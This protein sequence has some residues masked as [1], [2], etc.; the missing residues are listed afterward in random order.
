M[1]TDNVI[2]RH[3][4]MAF[5]PPDLPAPLPFHTLKLPR[6]T[7]HQ[8]AAKG[9]KMNERMSIARRI[10]CAC[11]V[12]CLAVGCAP[13]PE[14]AGVL[15]PDGLA[16]TLDKAVDAISV[17]AASD[18]PAGPVEQ[19]TGDDGAPPL[20]DETT[21]PPVETRS[22]TDPPVVPESPAEGKPFSLNQQI[23]HYGDAGSLLTFDVVPVDG[24]SFDFQITSDSDWVSVIPA[25][26]TIE[27]LAETIEVRIDRAALDTGTHLAQLSVSIGGGYIEPVYAVA[28][29]PETAVVM[30]EAQV[31]EQLRALPALQ[32]VHYSWTLPRFLYD[33]EVH[34]LLEEYVR[35]THAMCLPSG[36]Q[37]AHYRKVFEMAK[38]IEAE[39]PDQPAIRLGVKYA[40][41]HDVFPPNLPPTDFG[42]D[43]DAEI[44][45]FRQRLELIRDS[46]AQANLEADT[47]IEVAVFFLDSEIFYAR[48]PNQP[49]A[50]A[51]NAAIDAK[52]NAF[53]YLIR[54][55]FP[56]ANVDWYFRGGLHRCA[57]NDGWCRFRHFT[58]NELGDSYS[59]SLYSLPEY[60]YMREAFRRSAEI[61]EADGAPR[62]IPWIS[63][64]A[65]YHRDAAEGFEYS[66]DWDFDTWYPWQLGTELNH[67]W[68]A[69]N[70]ER[71]APW[72]WAE[73]AFFYPEPFGRAPHWGKHFVAYVRG[74]AGMDLALE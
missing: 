37:A 41:W 52:Y 56:D 9:K 60:G 35:I 25:S 50:D 23:L 24:A 65:G 62:L 71:F 72:D 63:L 47:H 67:P 10:G 68:Y 15:T 59:V 1:R 20:G 11:L 12:S 57:N 64:A 6:I 8:T 69:T 40:P 48:D 13:Q 39:N 3:D 44:E 74:A 73:Y 32:K 43:H 30:S 16:N 61:A 21:Q 36:A 27:G 2:R 49:G 66:W 34:P 19:V 31:L 53:F 28:F 46:V 58:G 45:T 33:P 14:T 17:D 38:R 7:A 42:P 4:A 18:D 51:W 54:E 29:Q 5:R 55:Y 70:P 22:P 26:G